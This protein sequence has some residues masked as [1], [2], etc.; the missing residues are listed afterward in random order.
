MVVQSSGSGPG[1]L[2]MALQHR[3]RTTQQAWKASC[4]IDVLTGANVPELVSSVLYYHTPY[5]YRDQSSGAPGQK[6]KQIHRDLDKTGESFEKSQR[7]SWT[8]CCPE[9]AGTQFPKWQQQSASMST[10]VAVHFRCGSLPLWLLYL[11]CGFCICVMAFVFV[12][13]LLYLR[14]GFCIWP[15]TS[16]PP[17]PSKMNVIILYGCNIL[18]LYQYDKIL[19]VILDFGYCCIIIWMLSFLVLK[20]TLLDVIFWTDQTVLLVLI[21]VFTHV[22]I[23]STL[24]VITDHDT[25]FCYLLLALMC[26][27]NITI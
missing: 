2:L 5:A 12:L 10:S 17:Y 16:G 23:I 15:D 22:V 20:A 25:W 19:Y 3:L 9:T 14:C 18:I 27:E 26:F 7:G 13:W 1:M 6:H 21:L 4:S 11:C 8:L 24:M